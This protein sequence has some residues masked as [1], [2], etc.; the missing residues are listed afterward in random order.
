MSPR[1]KF[2]QLIF[3]ISSCLFLSCEKEDPII[4][5]SSP[6]STTS[7]LLIGD[8]VYL[9]GEIKGAKDLGLVEHGFIIRSDSNKSF[10]NAIKQ[11][12]DGPP[13][14]QVFHGAVFNDFDGSGEYYVRAFAISSSNTYYGQA[15][16]FDGYDRRQ[17]EILDVTPR[18]GGK[19]EVVKIYGNHFGNDGASLKVKFGEYDCEIIDVMV[20]RIL[21]QTP[22]YKRSE[23][24]DIRIEK[25]DKVLV[26]SD[27]FEFI[28]PKIHSVTPDAGKRVFNFTITGENFSPIA[29]RNQVKLDNARVK[30]LGADEYN[31]QCE[32]DVSRFV[33]GRYALYVSVNETLSDHVPEL[34]VETPWKRLAEKPDLG[35][36]D[37]T[38]F[39]IGQNLFVCNGF[40]SMSP[41]LFNTEVW[42]YNIP[43]NS[44]ARMADFPGEP[45]AYASS[46]TI[47]AKAFV[48]SGGIKDGTLSDFWE[49]DSRTDTWTRKSDLPG[50]PRSQAQGFSHNE[51]GYFLGGLNSLRFEPDF[52]EYDPVNDSWRELA[53]FEG[54]H[55][56]MRNIV[57]RDGKVYCFGGQ[58]KFKSF[59][60]EF[61]R[62]V[63]NL[64]HSVIDSD[65]RIHRVAYDEDDCYMLTEHTS[66]LYEPEQ[67]LFRYD[68]EMHRL[69]DEHPILPKYRVMPG[70]LYLVDKRLIYGLGRGQWSLPIC[71]D[72]WMYDLR[73]VQ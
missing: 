48:G 47:G 17:P 71:T 21:I 6:V 30:V 73:E 13:S 3:L 8:S 40:Y 45:R 56:E 64:V 20:D 59:R 41:Y 28:G 43:S 25:R 55:E 63:W 32:I 60:Y 1:S 31:L 27:A 50:G 36:V 19:G 35:Y 39:I 61:E 4:S 72:S 34:N 29:W 67:R 65:L 22:N 46:F 57:V 49:Y 33:P 69:L 9:S 12:S 26:A 68:P 53:T 44:W 11:S 42:R 16:A 14:G 5:I 7:V 10:L 58:D 52:W 18:I 51:K 15:V 70:F 23:I 66:N 62:D 37:F 38:S 54:T 2:L 24:V